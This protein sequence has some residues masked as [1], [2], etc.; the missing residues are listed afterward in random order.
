MH[1][2]YCFAD[3]TNKE[4]RRIFTSVGLIAHVKSKL[5]ENYQKLKPFVMDLSKI[6][7]RK[8]RIENCSTVRLMKVYSADL[9]FEKKRATLMLPWC[10]R[11]MGRDQQEL[12][13]VLSSDTKNFD[14]F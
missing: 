13:I 5:C 8:N 2:C 7:L 4:N 1:E 3:G 11:N 10:D 6:E 9:K 12:L 14:S